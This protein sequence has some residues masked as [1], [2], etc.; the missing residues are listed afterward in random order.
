MFKRRTH[1]LALAVL[2]A[3]AATV[4]ASTLAAPL[5]DRF[6]YAGTL[7][8][9]ANLFFG[10]GVCDME[11]GLYDAPTGGNLVGAPEVV[12]SVAVV[13]FAFRVTLNASDLFG[14]DA[15]QGDERFLAIGTRCT[16]G[17]QPGG[18]PQTG[19]FTA[20]AERRRL[21][22]VPFALWAQDAGVDLSGLWNILGNTG[23][24]P[25]TNFVGTVDAAPLA[26][27][28]NGVER[29]RIGAGGGVGVG[30]TSPSDALHVDDPAGGV[31]VSGGSPH[32]TLD[33]SSTPG[34]GELGFAVD[35]DDLRLVNFVGGASLVLAADGSVCLGSGC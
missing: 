16:P 25:T 32:V 7:E 11:F 33:R 5:D 8:S 29:M 13:D 23:T 9:P 30:T 35:G 22:S 34:R 28:T 27:R 20:Q 6:G 4:R 1:V 15:F 10:N 31:T 19:P 14:P 3:A 12:P 24:Q 21:V 18:P 17:D 2:L 26:F